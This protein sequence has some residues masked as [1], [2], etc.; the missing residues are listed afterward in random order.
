MLT[1]RAA[2]FILLTTISPEV[3]GRTAK[4]DGT[5]R[6]MNQKSGLMKPLPIA[7]AKTIGMASILGNV[8]TVKPASCR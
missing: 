8:S 7:N 4:N 3:R 2:T 6:F 5:E 1:L